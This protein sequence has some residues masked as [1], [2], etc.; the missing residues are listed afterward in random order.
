M[1]SNKLQLLLL[2]TV[3]C[4]KIAKK[5]QK[6]NLHHWLKAFQSTCMKQF[7]TLQSLKL[8]FNCFQFYQDRIN[9]LAL[10]YTGIVF[11]LKR[12]IMSMLTHHWLYLIVMAKLKCRKNL[13]VMSQFG[14][15]NFHHLCNHIMHSLHWMSTMLV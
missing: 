12:F 14:N 1:T 15:V 5:M 3:Q 6:L 11:Q 4:C 2:Q 7:N 8:T 9:S 13:Y 10:N